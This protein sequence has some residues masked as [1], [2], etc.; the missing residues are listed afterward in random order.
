MLFKILIII[1]KCRLYF[2]SPKTQE[3]IVLDNEGIEYLKNIPSSPFKRFYA[4]FTRK[5]YQSKRGNIDYN[6]IM[7]ALN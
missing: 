6:H 3:L 4:L 1:Y 5:E 2:K 7:L